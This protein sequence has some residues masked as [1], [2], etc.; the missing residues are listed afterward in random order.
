MSG[1]DWNKF[2]QGQKKFVILASIIVPPL[3][4]TTM[5]IPS[6][7]GGQLPSLLIEWDLTIWDTYVIQFWIT[8]ISLIALILFKNLT[9]E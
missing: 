1:S 7:I 6:F 2:T 4:L 9:R 8:T 3:L 5:L